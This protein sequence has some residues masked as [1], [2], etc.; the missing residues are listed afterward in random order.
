[1]CE[2]LTL[3]TQSL[4]ILGTL[5]LSHYQSTIPPL[6]ALHARSRRRPTTIQPLKLPSHALDQL[7]HTINL[8]AQILNVA[9]QSRHLVELPPPVCVRDHFLNEEFLLFEHDEAFSQPFFFGFEFRD[10]DRGGGCEGI[11]TEGGGGVLARVGSSASV[12]D[13]E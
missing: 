12:Q 8:H 9:R 3:Q 7:R 11:D 1:M 4:S 6:R 13:G 5:P 10:P 2:G